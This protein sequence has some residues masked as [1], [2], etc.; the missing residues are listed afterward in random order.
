MIHQHKQA[1]DD[2][3]EDVEHENKEEIE[4][5]Q[6]EF[7]VQLEVEL[8]HQAAELTS[9]QASAD[10]QFSEEK[11]QT[12]NTDGQFSEE[13]DQTDK[14]DGQF[15]E[16]KDLTDNT[17]GQ[18]SE[19]KDQRD[20]SITSEDLLREQIKS[21]I[22]GQY[23]EKILKLQTELDNSVQLSKESTN[24]LESSSEG[25]TTDMQIELDE[26]KLRADISR[27][28]DNRISKMADEYNETIKNLEQKL[29]EFSTGQDETD[30]GYISDEFESRISKLTSEYEEKIRDLE[31]KLEQGL[32]N[33]ELQE[34]FE[35]EKEDL[36]S[37]HQK[38]LAEAE[39]RY[40]TLIEGIRSGDAPEVAEMIRD[41]FDQ[42]IDMA[43]TLMQQEFDETLEAEQARFM[44]QHQEM[45]DNF[46]SEQQKEAKELISKHKQELSDQRENLVILYESQ[47]R[48]LEEKYNDLSLKVVLPKSE[49]EQNPSICGT[50]DESVVDEVVDGTDIDLVTVRIDGLRRGLEEEVENLKINLDKKEAKMTELI[51]EKAELEK[52]LQE[53]E[54]KHLEEVQ[55]I[56]DEYEEKLNKLKSDLHE[57]HTEELEAAALD[58]DAVKS[59]LDEAQEQEL[60]D[61]EQQLSQ[62]YHKEIENLKRQHEIYLEELEEKHQLETKLESLTAK[63][64]EQMDE[65]KLILTRRER[66]NEESGNL[67]ALLRADLDHVNNERDAVQRTNEHLLKLLSDAV[68]TYMAVEDDI[69]KK[70]A[71]MLSD[72]SNEGSPGPHLD[73]PSGGEIGGVGGLPRDTN[74]QETS[75]LS[76]VTD[77]G[78]DLSQRISESIFQGPELDEHGEELLA[79]AGTRVQSSVSRL[80]GMID[81]TTTQL[82]EAKSVHQ[83]LLDSLATRTQ[84]S[85]QLT[86]RCQDL[87]ERLKEAVDAKEYLALE[88]HKAEGLI[89]GYSSEREMLTTQLQELEEKKEELVLDLET[90]RN[91]L[92]SLESS[93]DEASSLR[94]EMQRQQTVM[95][96]NVGLEA[97][98]LM[99]EVT[100]LNEDR[101]D[102]QQQLKQVQER[103]E[104]RIHELETT[105]EDMEHHYVELLEEKKKEILDLQLQLDSVEKQL[106]SNRQFI[107][108]QTAE[109]ELEREESQTQI[110][111]MKEVLQSKEKKEKAEDRLLGEVED[112]KQQLKTRMDSHSETMLHKEQLQRDLQDKS[113]SAQDLTVLVSQLEQEIDEKKNIEDQLRQRVEQLSDELVKQQELYEA[114]SRSITPSP[115]PQAHS[116]PEHTA[117]I[118]QR[119]E[120][121]QSRV[122]LEE[123]LARVKREEEDLI[124]EKEAL[125]EQVDKQ[126]K[127]ISALRNQL[128]EMRHRG[129]EY[130]EDSQ[131]ISLQEKL[132]ETVEAL[133]EKDSK[134]SAMMEKVLYQDEVLA[135]KDQQIKNL[136]AKIEELHGADFDKLHVEIEMLKTKLQ[137]ME[138]NQELENMKSELERLRSIEM[139]R[140]T[141]T[142]FS[143]DVSLTDAD[144]AQLLNSASFEK[145]SIH[146]EIEDSVTTKLEEI[147]ELEGDVLQLRETLQQKEE[148]IVELQK[149]LDMQSPSQPSLSPGTPSEE[150]SALNESLQE[151]EGMIAQMT[152][153]I[154][155]LHSEVENLTD[156]QFKLQEDFDTVQGMLEDKQREIEHLS[157]EDTE[158]Q[159]SELELKNI[160]E[161]AALKKQLTEKDNVIGERDEEIYTLNEKAEQQESKIE[162]LENEMSNKHSEISQ[163]CQEIEDLKL[164]VV[165]Y[166]NLKARLTEKESDIRDK[167]EEI[168][169][170]TEKSASLKEH[171]Q[172]AENLQKKLEEAGLLTPDQR[173][174][175]KDMEL[176]QLREEVAALKHQLEM[177]EK[178]TVL[179]ESV[180]NISNLKE[181]L[182]DVRDR[183][184][185]DN[186]ILLAESEDQ[187]KQVVQKME[188]AQKESDM[189]M[190][191]KLEQVAELQEELAKVRSEV[192][193][194]QKLVM[195]NQ[196][197]IGQ[198]DTLIEEKDAETK[199][200]KEEINELK[201]ELDG[202][203][204][205]LDVQESEQPDEVKEELIALQEELTR[206]KQQ[207][208]MV[209][210]LE[211]ALKDA[212]DQ[213]RLKEQHLGEQKEEYENLKEEMPKKIIDLEA[214][215]EE[216]KQ[217]K[218][219]SEDWNYLEQTSG[220]LTKATENLKNLEE[221][222]EQMSSQLTVRD[223]DNTQLRTELWECT[224]RLNDVTEKLK[225]TEEKLQQM[226]SQLAEREKHLESLQSELQSEQQTD[227]SITQKIQDMAAR[228]EE[229]KQADLIIREKEAE[230]QDV[231][232]RLKE[233]VEISEQQLQI[234]EQK[235][236]EYV[237][238]KLDIQ[239]AM[240][241]KDTSNK[242][243][244]Q[245]LHK[246]VV[247][248]ENELQKVRQESDAAK[249]E[250]QK[251]IDIRENEAAKLLQELE[252]LQLSLNDKE[253]EL[254]RTNQ[255]VSEMKQTFDEI[256]SEKDRVITELVKEKE[257]VSTKQAK[258]IADLERAV[259]LGGQK[260]EPTGSEDNTLQFLQAQIQEKDDNIQVLERK[261]TESQARLD[262]KQ[263]ELAQMKMNMD[264]MQTKLG[265][266][267]MLEEL[268]KQLQITKSTLLDKESEIDQLRNAE[269]MPADMSPENEMEL[270]KLQKE[271]YKAKVELTQLQRDR[272]AFVGGS[273]NVDA[274]DT[275]QIQQQ[276]ADAYRELDLYRSSASVPTQD[277]VKKLVEISENHKRHLQD[278]QEQIRKESEIQLAAFKHKQEEEVEKLQN[279][280]KIELE[281]R[282]GDTA[283]ELEKRHKTEMN[284]II[285]QHKKEMENF[286][287]AQSID[288]GADQISAEQAHEL[289]AE[290]S[291]TERLDHQLLGHLSV[292]P[293]GAAR[294]SLDARV[295]DLPPEVTVSEEKIKSLLS[296]MYNDGVQMLSMSELQYLDS[297]M[298]PGTIE[299]EADIRSLKA[300]WANE[301]Q[302]LLVAIQSLK[303]LLAQTHQMRGL[304][305]V[306]DISDWR[307][308]LLKAISYV[309]AKERDSLL[310]ELRS[311]VVS[312]PSE[313]LAEIQKLEQK[314]R[315]QDSHQQ[316]AL[317]QILGADRQSMLAEIRDLRAHTSISRIQHQEERERLSEQLSSVEDQTSKRER[318]L[319]R[320]IQLLEY[321]LQQE[322]ILQNDLKASL[323]VERSRTSE[324][325]SHLNREKNS[326]LDLHTENSSLSVQMAKL[327]DALEREQSRF[328]SV[329]SALE[330]EKGKTTSLTDALEVERDRMRH[331][332]AELQLLKA[333]SGQELSQETKTLEKLHADLT[334]ERERRIIAENKAEVDRITVETLKEEL[335]T[336]SHN[337]DSLEADYEP[338]LS[339]LRSALDSEQARVLE[340]TGALEREKV[341]TL[342]LRQ[343]LENTRSGQGSS[344]SGDLVILDVLQ[345]ELDSEK[346]KVT[347]LQ[348]SLQREKNNLA[349]VTVS[350]DAL[351]KAS[352]EEVEREREICRQMKRELDDLNLQ[353]I[354]LSR[355]QEQNEEYTN[356]IKAERNQVQNELK[357]LKELENERERR[358]DDE[359]L[360]E[361]RKVR[362]LEQERDDSRLKQ[363]EHE[364]E[365]QRL[366]QKCLDLEHQHT[367]LREKEI[368][369]VHELEESKLHSLQAPL[370]TSMSAVYSPLRESREQRERWQ[371]YRTQLESICQSLQFFVL[372]LN[373]RISKSQRNG[374]DDV[375]PHWEMDCVTLQRSLKDLLTE[376][377]QIETPLSLET[378]GAANLLGTPSVSHINERIL[379]HN[380]ELTGFVSRLSDEKMELRKT[381]SKLEEDI[382]QYRQREE[383]QEQHPSNENL[384]DAHITE[385][386][387]WAKE[388][389]SLQLGLNAAERELERLQ[390]DLR[391]ERERR[392]ASA[393]VLGAA[394]E[395]DREK[396][397]RL[398]GKYLKAESFRKA[399]VYQKKYLLLLLGGFQDC[400]ETTLALIAR[401]GAHPTVEELQRQQ[402]RRPTFLFRSAVR[403]VIA[404]SRMKYLVKKWRRATRVGSPV[405][406]GFV[407]SNQGY[408]PN[409]NSY[410]PPRLGTS[411][412]TGLPLRQPHASYSVDRS[413]FD[414]GLDN[415]VSSSSRVH[416][417]PPTKDYGNLR[418]TSPSNVSG[419]RRKILSSA[420]S[421]PL[422]AQNRAALH[423][424]Y[425][426]DN[427]DA[428][429]HDDYIQ[430]LENLQHRLGSLDRGN[431]L[432][433]LP[434]R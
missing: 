21:Q 271:L 90:T 339:Q 101:R 155:T 9:Q 327:K 27:E 358:R 310:A 83:E 72:D 69:S 407:D 82:V 10:G 211:N 294:N 66:E 315:T 102:L 325:S 173:S 270:Q 28:Y 262:Q 93:H 340:L 157:R 383:L 49:K 208:A 197:I 17:D 188:T 386:G 20:N 16:K 319:K 136:K 307:G 419:A 32:G 212:Q 104:S 317:D 292:P 326:C 38:D 360:E 60:K 248:M 341:V 48:E 323:D 408:M 74:I 365:S 241:E 257:E 329:T 23:E 59:D 33:I 153:Q 404:V 210:D 18:F 260:E 385:R 290:V 63:L 345:S 166:E 299:Q 333:S 7:K 224:S 227:P 335:Q 353:Q 423:P 61:M 406:S 81:D 432:R 88:L 55:R 298:A 161:M 405:M 121:Q 267:G 372:Q 137:S 253:M 162:H 215:I 300:A 237:Q 379:D 272:P 193:K 336:K 413:A 108:E 264:Q 118:A 402:N 228:L 145:V 205:K 234:V 35:A 284:Q 113:M 301:K 243:L 94:E 370:E 130:S 397:Q 154:E 288:M 332:D 425:S 190:D 230:L 5:L 421:L 71:R 152:E 354:D 124:Q 342:K 142:S 200:L 64:K 350:F 180:A 398:Y 150:L 256:C 110:N 213:L 420:Q 125:Q 99:L 151:K 376:I 117:I 209:L 362:K 84:E 1:L 259:E 390:T 416:H 175:Q 268:Q 261:V 412:R 396:M 203:R 85:E 189:Q 415:R 44:E 363:H 361:R 177:D 91:R 34:M 147:A 98:A 337:V 233:A 96:E 111:K 320:Q 308:E 395:T 57:S 223:D 141:P 46:V 305:K 135:Q 287:R 134:L 207:T 187:R 238:L 338:L 373:E 144:A 218:D 103:Y 245:Q 181:E 194:E 344:S 120:N 380:A 169:R 258:H 89:E 275:A 274:S 283:R 182:S 58:T 62:K 149:K 206:A 178:S 232:Q 312:H 156:F 254:Q 80:L 226:C 265:E 414:P 285:S 222:I 235:D 249:Q 240:S 219:A 352:R 174:S 199:S 239:Q 170:L 306:G 112:L 22:C 214:Q 276:L 384:T 392:V 417:T 185:A 431:D 65:E 201:R 357:T 296:R 45:M 165:A 393:A 168:Q 68:K 377:R 143:G 100:R 43:K 6:S 321:K 410:S 50:E 129:G 37:E 349:D 250:L 24:K 19:K 39:D 159:N 15:S 148:E 251:T 297:H 198:K 381:L 231:K 220:Q 347:Q 127:Q 236:A 313:D 115:E 277:Y 426:L 217:M 31:S 411:P 282:I 371:I 429:V 12:D 51:K 304:D 139:Q 334:K 179:E 131:I 322:K 140:N 79:D 434:H 123:E 403:V 76:N 204:Q 278:I 163:K 382:W 26:N 246:A 42:E 176:K 54:Q 309:F 394:P 106:K 433:G 343:S 318:Q 273:D 4:T 29:Q 158:K 14:N 114:L 388:R 167:D 356:R 280:H 75:V 295:R 105:G 146:K 52:T 281:Q 8:K 138:K 364:L 73:L 109:R 302:G 25:E 293:S 40:D 418:H 191:L 13:K 97:Q 427:D 221:K 229:S 184:D 346:A 286:K 70:L 196:E 41:K 255:D 171:L 116:S 30:R 195:D 128:D 92:H 263:N 330:E 424:R 303:D 126:H 430:R 67:A 409:S 133:E 86:S 95:Q 369:L 2:L 428:T 400:E 202:V 56:K 391:I 247:D 36:E 324:L 359:R 164:E 328:V 244:K 132:S 366:R 192:E 401:M 77:E 374:I 375:P 119:I 289:Q 47:I 269:S 172:I 225:S 387:A 399:L 87:E 355:R 216:L 348:N 3:R 252:R 378:E 367:A 78:L 183:L 291:A 422:S 11:D 53:C 266:T 122:P 351:R 316:A 107:D 311:H 186:N 368:K 279:L 389:L 160:Q 314:I 242:E 331:L